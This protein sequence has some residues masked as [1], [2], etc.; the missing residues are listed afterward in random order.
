MNIDVYRNWAKALT[1]EHCAN[2]GQTVRNWAAS[3]ENIFRVLLEGRI[4][5]DGAHIGRAIFEPCSL[6]VARW[7][8]L[9]SLLTGHDRE[10]SN[11]VQAM[12]YAT[13]FLVPLNR[14]YGESHPT[15]ATGWSIAAL[16]VQMIRNGSLHGFTPKGVYD[17]ATASCIG[18]AMTPRLV[19]QAGT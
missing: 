7:E 5:A 6:I 1:D 2:P 8:F 17:D 10:R 15:I 11:R 4:E 13:E 9:G 19:D 3:W 14:R 18:W 12:A 16:L